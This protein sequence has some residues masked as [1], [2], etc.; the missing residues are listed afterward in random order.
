MTNPAPLERGAPRVTLLG[1]PFDAASSYLRGAAQ[2]PAAIRTALRSAHT[3]AFTERGMDS[4]E[5]A[6]AGDVSLGNDAAHAAAARAAIE[7]AVD[8]LLQDSAR[9]IVLGGDHSITYPVLRAVRPHAPRLTIVHFDAHPDLYDELGGDRWSHACPFARAMEDGLADRLVQVGIRASTA[10]QR[11]QASRFG[12]ETVDMRAWGRG[13]RPAVG[14]AVYVSVDLDVLDPAFAPGVS[15]LEPGGLST[16]ELLDAITSLRGEIIAC[17]VV[18]LN[19]ARDPTGVTA[20]AAAKIVKE[21]AGR[22]T[23]TASPIRPTAA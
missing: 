23:D 12:V 22:M 9:P 7:S 19:P 2:A 18:E 21:L 1:V 10:H 17:D 13:V 6:D 11:E 16:R 14:G 3:N 20:A 5:V 8:A 15:H 4:G